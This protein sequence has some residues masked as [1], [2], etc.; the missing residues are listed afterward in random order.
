MGLSHDQGPRRRAAGPQD[1]GGRAHRPRHRPHR[2]ARSKAQRRRCARLRP[3]PRSGQGRRRRALPRRS[4]TTPWNPDGGQGILQRRRPADDLGDAGIQ[5]LDAAGGRRR[6][7]PPQGCRRR[8][9]RQDQRSDQSARLAELQRHLRYD[10]QSLGSRPHAGRLIRRVG[11]GARRRLRT[12]VD[13][14]RH[15]RLAARAGALLRRLWA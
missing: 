10:Q 11:R 7:H 13:R 2:D 9:P 15:R 3:R 6:N 1:F 4:A 14:F 12:A 8:H 5:G